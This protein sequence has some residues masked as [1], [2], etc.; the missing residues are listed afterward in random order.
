[1]SIYYYY[2]DYMIAF[3]ETGPVL[4][5]R[6]NEIVRLPLDYLAD[7]AVSSPPSAPRTPPPPPPP[8]LFTYFYYLS[9]E[10]SHANEALQFDGWR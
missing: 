10:G 4:T 3:D 5:C 6:F 7:V 1:M 9:E 8:E 2:Y